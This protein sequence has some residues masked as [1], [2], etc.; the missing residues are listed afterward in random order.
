MKIRVR[1]VYALSSGFAAGY[2]EG[3]GFDLSLGV[4]YLLKYNPLV[5]SF[6][7]PMLYHEIA[8]PIMQNKK[9]KQL[10]Q[11]YNDKFPVPTMKSEGKTYSQMD[12]DEKEAMEIILR[13]S[14]EFA[15]RSKQSY[16]SA[17]FKQGG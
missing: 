6:I 1:D 2:L 10:E 15:S 16:I 3:K 11:F 4:D 13:R 8:F 5:L 7:H 12:E 9:R 14:N 17:S